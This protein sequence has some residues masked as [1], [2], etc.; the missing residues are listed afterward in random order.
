[1]KK[2]ISHFV[3]IA[4]LGLVTFFAIPNR[5]QAAPAFKGQFTLTSDVVWNGTELPAGKYDFTLDSRA[6]PAKILLHGPNG[7]MFVLTSAVSGK[8]QGETS[9]MTVERRNGTRYI[10]ELYLAELGIDLRYRA[11]K[12][13]EKEIAQGPVTTEHIL[14]AMNGK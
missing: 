12:L 4:V 13:N 6:L 14:V 3:A 7:Y 1:M 5:V 2:H 9:N 11:P 10:S 8:E